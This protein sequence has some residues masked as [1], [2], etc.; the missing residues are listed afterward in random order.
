MIEDRS[1]GTKRKQGS[2]GTGADD[3]DDD[4]DDGAYV[5]EEAAPKPKA[6]K[7]GQSKKN[8]P[9]GLSAPSA[10]PRSVRG[11]LRSRLNGEVRSVL[12]SALQSPCQPAHVPRPPMPERYSAGQPVRLESDLSPPFN[13]TIARSQPSG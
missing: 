6:S 7:N 1:G 3:D 5:P 9:A 11:I 12:Q 2:G 8:K 10:E 4:D 13:R